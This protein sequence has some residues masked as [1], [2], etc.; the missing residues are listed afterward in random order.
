ACSTSAAEGQPAPIIEVGERPGHAS[1]DRGGHAIA[2]PR[3]V[4][5]RPS[6]KYDCVRMYSVPF[7]AGAPVV[8]RRSAGPQE[9]ARADLA[10]ESLSTKIYTLTVCITPAR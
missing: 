9:A 5:A 3:G 10:A 2:F 7:H 6:A 8:G 4:F 1:V